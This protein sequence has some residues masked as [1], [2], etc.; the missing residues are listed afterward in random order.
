VIRSLGILLSITASVLGAPVVEESISYAG[1]RFRVVKT[2]P[3]HLTIVWKDAQGQPYRTF[4][5]VQ[6]AYAKKGAKIRFL[7]NA[8][9]YEE[10]GIPSGLHV[11]NGKE[12]RPL[13]LANAPGNFFLKPNGVFRIDQTPAGFKAS[14]T[15][16]E[17]YPKSAVPL[18]GLQSGPLLL[19]NGKRHPAFRNGSPNKLLRN[20]VGV[21]DKG[22]VVFAITDRGQSVNLWDFSGLF[23]HLGCKD[24]LFLD[25]DISQSSVNPTKPVESNRFGAMFV[26][27]DP[28]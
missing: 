13:N 14:I 21:D 4:H 8:G 26:I 9:I 20:G 5:Q 10:G 3:E 2:A 1:T 7:M 11:E 15:V 17:A 18:L 24:A 28:G 23:L 22:Q 6:A 25:G 12:L 16:S 19:S 27:A